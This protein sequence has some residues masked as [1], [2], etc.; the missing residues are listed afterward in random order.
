MNVNVLPYSKITIIRSFYKDLG[1]KMFNGNRILFDF[2]PLFE[3]HYPQIFEKAW[4]RKIIFHALLEYLKN[5]RVKELKKL[6]NLKL[7]QYLP[8][9]SHPKILKYIVKYLEFIKPLTLETFQNL[10]TQ[11]FDIDFNKTLYNSIYNKFI[12][13]PHVG[14]RD[15]A[16]Y[17]K[18]F[19]NNAFKELVS[20]DFLFQ[21]RIQEIH[22]FVK[23]L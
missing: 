20:N 11:S 12:N 23:T 2:I 8:H 7:Y 4:L 10:A 15:R 19:E 14:T 21:I 3:K 9:K 5:N 18:F 17:I 13:E 6:F 1:C 16:K 22:T